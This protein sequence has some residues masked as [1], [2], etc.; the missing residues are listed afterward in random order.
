MDQ[1]FYDLMCSDQENENA[2]K[3]LKALLN[4]AENSGVSQRSV[5][6]VWEEVEQKYL[7]GAA[8]HL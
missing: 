1:Y 3:Q 7:Y 5:N 2:R 6:D 8:T 4:E